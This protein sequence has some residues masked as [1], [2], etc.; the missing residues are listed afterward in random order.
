MKTYRFYKA[1]GTQYKQEAGTRAGAKNLFYRL[2]NAACMIVENS[3][4]KTCI[5]GYYNIIEYFKR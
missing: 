5:N 2:K 3:S 1:D 4:S